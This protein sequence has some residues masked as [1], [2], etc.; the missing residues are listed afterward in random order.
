MAFARGDVV[1]VPFPFTDLSAMD[2][3]PAIVLNPPDYEDS[4]G[5][6][7]VAMVTA[8]RHNL[9]TDCELLDWQSAGLRYPSW[10]RAKLFTLDARL[11]RFS[12]GT[13]T[14]RDLNAVVARVRVALAL[15]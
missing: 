5:D 4:S 2:L 7:I 1:L 15:S 8:Q 9:P 14:M 3:R 13:L 6:V 10:A 11:V 12:P